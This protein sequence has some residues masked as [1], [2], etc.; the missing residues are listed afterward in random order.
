V[1]RHA[2]TGRGV[3]GSASPLQDILGFLR[4]L[5]ACDT[6]NPPRAITADGQLAATIRNA[7]PGFDIDLRDLGDG[8]LAI[9]ARRGSSPVLFNVHMDTVPVAPGWTTDPHHLRE[10]EDRAFGL[11]TCDTKGAAAVLFAIA[12]HT[13][14]PMHLLLTTDEEAGQSRCIRTFLEDA[15]PAELAVIAE[16]TGALARFEHRGLVSARASFSGQSG[17]ASEA[18]RRSA[19]HDAATLVTRALDLEG[20]EEQ[21]LNFGRI[22]GGLKPN[23]IAGEAELLFG[24]RCRPGTDH[25]AFLRRIEELT[26]AEVSPRFTGPALPSDADGPSAAAQ[27]RAKEEARRLGLPVGDAV[28]F[29]TEASL[30]SEAGIPSIVLGAGSIAQAHAPDEFVTYDQLAKLFELYGKVLH[31]FA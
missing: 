12:G 2:V 22:E 25:R 13:D 11:G 17:H 21:R 31:G 3:P 29:W 15:P 4:P 18:G 5:I 24:F 8:C 9:E 30:F 19:V 26:D 23:M 7:L 10:T 20:A 14:L 6:C 16:P 28:D 1:T 27:L